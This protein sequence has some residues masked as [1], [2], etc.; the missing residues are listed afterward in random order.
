[1]DLHWN[2]ASL[3]A[4]VLAVAPVTAP[5]L[6]ADEIVEDFGPINEFGGWGGGSGFYDNPGTG[7]VDGAED[8]YVEI[9]NEPNAWRFGMNNQDAAYQ[10][11]WIAA[12]VRSVSLYVQD[13]GAPQDFEIHLALSLDQNNTWIHTLAMYP[14]SGSWAFYSIDMENTVW[15]DWVQIGFG[16]ADEAAFLTCLQN[17]QKVL[18]RHDDTSDGFDMVI[19]NDDFIQGEMGFDR[20]I[21]GVDCP[22]DALPGHDCNDNGV[23]DECDIAAGTSL[24]QDGDGVPDECQG[25]DCPADVDDD[26]D[27]DVNDLLAVLGAW[28]PCLGCPEDIV[29]DEVVNVNDVLAVLSE[30]GPCR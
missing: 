15:T 28:G 13:T 30:W 29:P 12:G 14:P 22:A 6:A 24:D 4:A 10:G 27:V 23:V 17:V 20:F 16:P 11:D 21:I 1:M 19:A 7:G 3:C 8:G 26:G 5:A 2:V 18:L 25:T 9:I